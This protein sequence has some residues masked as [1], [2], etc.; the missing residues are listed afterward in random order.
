MS[1]ER[2]LQK[3]TGRASPFLEPAETIRAAAWGHASELGVVSTAADLARF[4]TALLSGQLLPPPL[5]RQMLATF[6]GSGYGLGVMAVHTP[7]G[8]AWG[9]NGDFP[10]YISDAFTTRG[11]TRQAIVL[12]N[13]DVNG[14]TQ[15]STD[16]DIAIVAGLCGHP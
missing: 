13:S 6:P 10:G 12:A 1:E 11:G 3:T 15:E 9:H 16:V 7:C 8:G 2:Q 4:Y 5:L 14:I